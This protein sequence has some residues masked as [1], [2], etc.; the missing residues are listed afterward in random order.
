[1]P[2]WVESSGRMFGL[3]QGV[4]EMGRFYT[5]N[6]V[7]Y[8]RTVPTIVIAHTFSASRDTLVSYSGAY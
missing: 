3:F 6:T 8:L 4:V 5:V 7:E 2:L 1:M